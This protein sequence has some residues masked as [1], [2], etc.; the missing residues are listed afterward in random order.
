MTKFLTITAVVAGFAIPS[1]AQSA[2]ARG[3]AVGHGGNVGVRSSSLRG[4][5]RAIIANRIHGRDSYTCGTRGYRFRGG[6][7]G[8][9]SCLTGRYCRQGYNFGYA[10][11]QPCVYQFACSTPCE[12]TVVNEVPVEEI[13]VQ[14]AYVEPTCYQFSYTPC[15][16]S[17]CGTRYTGCWNRGCDSRGTCGVWGHGRLGRHYNGRFASHRV[18]ASHGGHFGGHTSHGG[19]HR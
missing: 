5:S 6:C 2:E 17:Y 1:V 15:A 8:R 3:T 12:Q 19:G 7:D 9:N 11:Y 14:T 10:C 16:T 18:V 4:G 13:P